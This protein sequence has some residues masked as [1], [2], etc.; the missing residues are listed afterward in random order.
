MQRLQDYARG[1]LNYMPSGTEQSS[2]SDDNPGGEGLNDGDETFI[3]DETDESDAAVS[4]EGDELTGDEDLPRDDAHLEE[5]EEGELEEED[6]DE[7]YEEDEEEDEGGDEEDSDEDSDS[8]LDDENLD[9]DSTDDECDDRPELDALALGENGRKC[10]RRR[11]K[12]QDPNTTHRLVDQGNPRRKRQWSICRPCRRLI[13][14][15]QWYKLAR[16]R[17]TGFPPPIETKW[18][19]GFRTRL[20][21]DCEIAECRLIQQIGLGGFPMPRPANADDMG[22]Y[23]SNTCTCLH[24][25]TS[26]VLCLHHRRERWADLRTHPTQI[27]PTRDAHRDW[28]G[29]MAADNTVP[30]PGNQAATAAPTRVATWWTTSKSRRACRCGQTVVAV[31]QARVFQ[32]MAC[33]GIIYDVRPNLANVTV[34]G[35]LLPISQQ[36]NS[37][38]HPL[39]LAL[40]R[41]KSAVVIP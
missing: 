36:W 21:S 32:C 23:P 10:R 6:E 31:D 13:H 37:R 16:T 17:I 33:E 12:C 11:K 3:E 38:T 41:P 35:G 8:D 27:V 15:Q 26:N 22:D 40:L 7:E 18:W 24:E 20:C 5:D 30:L 2:D 34:P 14:D 1:A 29:G 25:L 39:D 9:G 19:R 28:L 4:P